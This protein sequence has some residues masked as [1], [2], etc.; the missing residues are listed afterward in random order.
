MTTAIITD[1]PRQ[2][3]QLAT[4]QDRI[5]PPDP[6]QANGSYDALYSLYVA[7]QSGGPMAAK[8]S[9]Q[10]LRK[11]RP[12]LDEYERQPVLIHADQ[13]RYLTSPTYMLSD[14]A[15]YDK[16]F[17]VL[18]GPSGSGKSFIALDIAGRISLSASVV[19]IAGEGL[20]GYAARWEAWKD[21]NNI[22]MTP[23]LYFYAEA[24]QLMNDV[25]VLGFIE[26]IR[27]HSP[28]MIII[29]TM[30]RSAVGLEENSAR[31]VGMFV[32][33]V[34]AM[35]AALDCAALVVHHTGKVGGTMR[36]S[37]A[38]YGAAD[39][40]LSVMASDGLITVSNHP[41]AG[42]KN[43][44]SESAPAL[45]LRLKPHNAEGYCGAV[46]VPAEQ[47]TMTADDRLTDNQ[48]LI[49]DVLDGFEAGLSGNQIIEA[50]GLP[51]TSFYRNIKTLT[52]AAL[53]SATDSGFI[54]TDEG[55]KAIK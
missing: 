24:L 30:A 10:A 4:T 21:F 53:V 42:G 52:K 16:A 25:D 23:R 28:R 19:Y 12:E 9:W 40:V 22:T 44:Y 55:L 33:A 46:V 37:S 8:G 32:H 2:Y 6:A 17:N 43:K 14:Y 1:Y 41:D 38:L 35:R 26:M 54:I 5:S 31:D 51:K 27:V 45:H 15:V 13:L 20:A 7:H 11:M 39:S 18:Y 29:D 3:I 49:L 50:T 34:D 48:R 36:G 47:V